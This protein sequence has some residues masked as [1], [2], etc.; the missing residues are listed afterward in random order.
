MRGSHAA[1]GGRAQLPMDQRLMQPEG[2]ER[3]GERAVGGGCMRGATTHVVALHVTPVGLDA[4]GSQDRDHGDAV[5]MPAC[6]N[7]VEGCRFLDHTLRF[8]RLRPEG[9]DP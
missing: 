5:E 1:A 9:D 3:Q 6:P 7:T 8:R 2:L 4:W